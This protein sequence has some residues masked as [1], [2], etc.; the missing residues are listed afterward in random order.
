METNAVKLI[1]RNVIQL[2]GFVVFN[3]GIFAYSIFQYVQIVQIFDN[4]S[5]I[6]NPEALAIVRPLL[7]VIPI[8]IALF[9]VAY[10]Y[11]AW[12]L[13]QE[14]G[15][16][17]YKK[18]GANPK[19]R[20]THCNCLANHWIDRYRTYQILLMLVKFDCFFALGFLIQ[21][22]TLQLNISDPEFWITIVAIPV[23][24]VCFFLAIYG[25]RLADLEC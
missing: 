10:C 24:V 22:L 19:M 14:F 5:F 25:V 8:I 16:K 21:F 9:C 3:V 2:W 6:T 18:I 20:S 1:N 23:A 4:T 13:Y 12:K 7:Y 17:I 15:W 11:L